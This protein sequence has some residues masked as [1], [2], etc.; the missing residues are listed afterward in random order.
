MLASGRLSAHFAVPWSTWRLVAHRRTSPANSAIL[1]C[2]SLCYG[3][4]DE[5]TRAIVVRRLQP[6]DF[7]KFPFSGMSVAACLVLLKGPS[8]LS[9][10]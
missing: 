9:N 7:P 3:A 1:E 6:G 10:K 5:H 2:V 4:M 8:Q